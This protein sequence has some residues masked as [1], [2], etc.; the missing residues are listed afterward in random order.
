MDPAN[1]MMVMTPCMPPPPN[2][3]QNKN[4]KTTAYVG[5]LSYMSPERLEAEEYSFPSDI[6]ALGMVVYELAVGQSPYPS[7]DK[8]ILLSE[9]MKKMDAPNLDNLQG[10]SPLLK[11]FSRRCLHKDPHQRWAA[12]DLL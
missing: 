10:V 9:T 11:D 8:P 1:P 3:Y 5:T 12:R 4:M 7:T 2:Q 6:W